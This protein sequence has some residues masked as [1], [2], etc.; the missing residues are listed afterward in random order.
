MQLIPEDLI[1]VLLQQEFDRITDDPKKE[2][3]RWMYEPVEENQPALK[4]ITNQVID[5]WNKEPPKIDFCLHWQYVEEPGLYIDFGQENDDQDIGL[6]Q[7][8]EGE[9]SDAE[10]KPGIYY[11]NLIVFEV[12][13]CVIWVM[14]RNLFWTRHLYYIARNCIIKNVP[15]FASNGMIN[16]RIRGGNIDRFTQLLPNV[17]F[18]RQINLAFQ[19]GNEMKFFEAAPMGEELNVEYDETGL[20][21]YDDPIIRDEGLEADGTVTYP[22]I[23]EEE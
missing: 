5:F 1:K 4:G 2:F 19:Y 9:V 12:P 8:L 15:T 22:F 20:A 18:P 21:S 13:T 7:F 17:L 10:D 14:T 16:M 23:A 3:L 11:K 6:N